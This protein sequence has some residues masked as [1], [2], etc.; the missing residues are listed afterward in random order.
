MLS[1]LLVALGIVHQFFPTTHIKIALAVS[2]LIPYM[3]MRK[4]IVIS[5]ITPRVAHSRSTGRK[6]K[7]KIYSIY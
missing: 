1:E 6:K 5:V 2:T 7:K 4:I 3:Y